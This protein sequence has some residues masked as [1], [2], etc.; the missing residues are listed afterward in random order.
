MKNLKKFISLLLVLSVVCSCFITA[1]AETTAEA[2][3]GVLTIFSSPPSS[4]SS[5]GGLNLGHAFLSFKNTSYSPIL[6]GALNVERGQE[7]TFGTWQKGKYGHDGIWYNLESYCINHK[8]EMSNRVSKSMNVTMKNVA[9][10]N[11][12][13]KT[14]DSWDY[15]TNCSSFASAVWD[16][17]SEFVLT[18]LGVDTPNALARGI[19]SLG[20]YATNQSVADSSPYG[21][22]KTSVV[23]GVTSVSFVS[24]NPSNV[25]INVNTNVVSV[26]DDT[27][28]TILDNPYT[29]ND[30]V[31]L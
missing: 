8:G 23:N 29:V 14:N 17:I 20:G 22:L 27:H 26:I 3:V 30:G 15:F 24:V 13:I 25:L 2:A 28:I 5:S 16:S 10:I 7:I 6:I 19:K 12:M 18:P 4:S 31:N 21:Y 11:Y 9:T 1:S